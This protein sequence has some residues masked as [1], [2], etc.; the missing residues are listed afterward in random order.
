MFEVSFH[1]LLRQAGARPVV[2]V[3]AISVSPRLFAL[4]G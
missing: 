3:S 2:H 4:S 1:A